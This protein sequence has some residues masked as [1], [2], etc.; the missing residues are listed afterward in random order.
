MSQGSWQH[1]SFR[2]DSPT[3]PPRGRANS[4]KYMEVYQSAT[5]VHGKLVIPLH[6]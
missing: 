3:Q 2:I 6:P 4:E 1:Y 5:W